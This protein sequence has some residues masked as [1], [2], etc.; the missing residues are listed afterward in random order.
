MKRPV[1]LLI[2]LLCIAMLACQPTPKSDIV[3]GLGARAIQPNEAYVLRD[4]LVSIPSHWTAEPLALRDGSVIITVDAEISYPNLD[5]IA[6]PEVVPE[7]I[8]VQVLER[9]LGL[10]RDGVKIKLNPQDE[11]FTA[12]A[13]KSEIEQEIREATE[14]LN[15]I[16]NAI[17]TGKTEEQ[18]VQ[19]RAEQEKHIASL[20][21]AY[22][23]APDDSEVQYPSCDDL[24]SLPLMQAE[25]IDAGGKKFGEMQLQACGRDNDDKRQSQF[26]ISAD[27]GKPICSEPITSGADAMCVGN[28]LLGRLG[29]SD[30]YVVVSVDEG[31]AGIWVNLGRYYKGLSYCPLVSPALQ[32]D[33]S[34]NLPWHDETLRLCV[35]RKTEYSDGL[36]L[37][38]AGWYG[39]SRPVSDITENAVLFDFSN[40]QAQA[41]QSLKNNYAW[42]SAEIKNREI[43]INR[44][45]LGYRRVPIK[46]TKSRYML[47]PVWTFQGVI[48]ETLI[49]DDGSILDPSPRDFPQQV[50][51]ILSALDGSVLYNYAG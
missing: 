40:I 39:R 20:Q 44:I 2:A 42:L 47:I 7:A 27:R 33:S 49:Q 41:L 3:I 1:T 43:A 50:I 48:T 6:I 13:T 22:R 26:Y 17:G 21:E 24:L 23:T 34:F 18:I 8:D 35:D 51:L 36:T 30:E 38:A 14:L 25:L 19:M 29:L 16:D 37:R 28:E 11:D 46:D 32:W 45:S 15:I 12:R 5:K 4:S 9:L 31:W 10:F